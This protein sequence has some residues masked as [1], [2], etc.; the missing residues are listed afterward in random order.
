LVVIYLWIYLAPSQSK[1][2][3]VWQQ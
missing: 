2:T 1:R 3:T